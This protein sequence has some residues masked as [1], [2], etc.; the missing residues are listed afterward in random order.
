MCRRW[1]RRRAAIEEEIGV[2]IGGWVCSCALV[3]ATKKGVMEPLIEALVLQ[4]FLD[5]LD[6][7][8]RFE[9]F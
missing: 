9:S 7:I 3:R 2:S 1:N 6:S 8:G 4:D 5:C